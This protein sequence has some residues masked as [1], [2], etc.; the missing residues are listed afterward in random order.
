MSAMSG[1]SATASE[2]GD[3]AP[4]RSRPARSFRL[5]FAAQREPGRSDVSAVKPLGLPTVVRGGM[6]GRESREDEERVQ[7]AL[8]R[9]QRMFDAG[10]RD[11]LAEPLTTQHE[12]GWW[13]APPPAPR[14]PRLEHHI[15][16]SA[17]LKERLR[18]L[19][20]DHGLCRR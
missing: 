15:R 19:A 14:D 11:R 12:Y 18:I 3:A 6:Y 5:R 2:P 13:G 16:D 17:W 4:E 10:P 1:M 7:S 9:V 20:A 8:R